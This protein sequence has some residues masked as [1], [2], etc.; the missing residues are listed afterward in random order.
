MGYVCEH[1]VPH[2]LHFE[3]P[4]FPNN[5]QEFYNIKPL[6]YCEHIFTNV[7]TA[8]ENPAMDPLT[9]EKYSGYNGN[10]ILK[11]FSKLLSV[12]IQTERKC[13]F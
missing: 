2:L 12:K 9:P 6:W 8:A 5:Y 13:K 10:N 7:Y 3:I 11:Y 1:G 4:N